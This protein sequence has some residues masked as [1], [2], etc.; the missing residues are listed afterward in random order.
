MKV[1]IIVYPGSNCDKD[2]YNYFTHHGCECFYIWHQEQQ[3]EKHIDLLVL[4]GG[5]AYGDRLYDKATGDYTMEPGKMASSCPVKDIIKYAICNNIV[6]LGI[7]NGF[8]ILIEMGLLPGKL[9]ENPDKKFTCK[10][11]KCNMYDVLTPFGFLDKKNAFETF[12]FYV[13]NRYGRYAYDSFGYYNMFNSDLDSVFLADLIK[14]RQIFL[15][16]TNT[17]DYCNCSLDNIAGI[18]STNKK[19]F[20]IMPHFERELDNPFFNLFK[21][22]IPNINQE[23]KNEIKELM[24]SEHIS[25]K[26]TR[27][28][29][30]TLHT[31]EDHVIQGPGENAG[32]VDIGNGYA[33]AMRMES[34]N[35]PIFIDP[36]HGAST[37][38]GGILRDIFTMGA[39]P[40]ALL[41]FLRFGTDKHNKILLKEAINGISYYGNCIGVPNVGGDLY[42]SNT[43]NFNPLLNVACIGLVKHENII[44]G[45]ALNENS[46][47]IYVGNK[48]GNDGIGG[49]VMASKEFDENV[50]NE[51]LKKNIQKGDSFLEKLL[52]EAC[53]EIAEQKLA[54]GMQ[55]MGAG[56]LLCSSIEVVSRGRVK[57]SKPLGCNMFVENVPIKDYKMSLCDRLIS[58]SQERML[59]V[60]KPENKDKIFDI[61]KKWD[62]EYSIVGKVD[63]SGKY[64]VYH[65]DTL[66]YSEG[67]DNFE[68]PKEDWDDSQ[69]QL[70]NKD[71][72]KIEKI[73][74]KTLWES[75]DSTIGGRTIKGPLDDGSYSILNVPEANKK[76]IITWGWDL[77]ECIKKTETYKNENNEEIK[78][79][80]AI[81]CMNFG[82]PCDCMG[83]FSQTI[84]ELR[85][86]CIEN[87][88]P[89]VG[90]NVSLY[91]AT[92]GTSIIPTPVIVLVGSIS[93]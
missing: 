65:Y 8:Q 81:N 73:H 13:A 66:L 69:L 38:V 68:D 84:K 53:L 76:I 79:L 88:V 45:N 15:K 39:R 16:Y 91:N 48:T 87:K 43:Y 20:G 10:K 46:L 75:Y 60:C 41:D 52:L 47:L 86:T 18:C 6:I 27:K 89:I 35:H 57:T 74:N 1:G 80:C 37:G 22:Y 29:L 56:G 51:D 3:L 40:I 30:K 44:Y 72:V 9:L 25:Y 5:F 71:N 32:I 50:N 78:L 34:H 82:H 58:E 28:Y 90:G 26:S 70:N 83:S 23:F 4:P 11:V 14:N 67:M 63:L 49:A 61:F 31:Q 21:K 55:D 93:Y 12:D 85:E 24:E 77:N 54:E 7:C 36:F 19:I 42:M 62:L 92:F 64:N 2:T 59:I 17:E 33:L